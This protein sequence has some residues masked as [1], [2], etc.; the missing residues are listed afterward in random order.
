MLELP[1]FAVTVYSRDM[2]SESAIAGDR[3][4]KAC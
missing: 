1:A 4:I 2:Q 3:R